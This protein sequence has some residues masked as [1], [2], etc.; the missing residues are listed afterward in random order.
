MMVSTLKCIMTCEYG[1][2]PLWGLRLWY[3]FG[4]VVNSICNYVWVIF[5]YKL[6][7]VEGLLGFIFRIWVGVSVTLPFVLER[8]SYLSEYTILGKWRVELFECGRAC[9]W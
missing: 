9:Y 6:C 1:K 4:F 8:C 7:P 2:G 5:C 3:H